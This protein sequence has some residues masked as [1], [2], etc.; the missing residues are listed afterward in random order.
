MYRFA[1]LGNPW[2][3]CK[4][5]IFVVHGGCGLPESAGTKGTLQISVYT[6]RR[7]AT[8]GWYIPVGASISVSHWCLCAKK[9]TLSLTHARACVGWTSALAGLFTSVPQDNSVPAWETC[10]KCRPWGPSP[11]VLSDGLVKWTGWKSFRTFEVV[12]GENGRGKALFK[13]F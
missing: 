5:S 3:L 13:A 6:K 2:G 11:D 12:S 8:S 4:F 10:W 1:S 7:D 9:K